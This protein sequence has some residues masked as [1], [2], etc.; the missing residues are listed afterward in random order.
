MGPCHIPPVASEE[1]ECEFVKVSGLGVKKGG[2]QK[3]K[4]EEGV[5]SQ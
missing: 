5:V 3:G 4:K 1:K 2:I